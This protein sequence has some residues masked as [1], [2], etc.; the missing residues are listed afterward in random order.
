MK[1]KLR[2]RVLA[3]L[4]SLVL[5]VGLM[6]GMS[7]TAFAQEKYTLTYIGP[8][9]L[10]VYI[11]RNNEYH[12]IYTG[13]SC[14]IPTDSMVNP[15]ILTTFPS[16]LKYVFSAS[17]KYLLYLLSTFN[18]PYKHS[19]FIS[20]MRFSSCTQRLQS[21]TPESVSIT[22]EFPSMEESATISI[23]IPAPTRSR[24]SSL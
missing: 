23:S 17:R 3:A 13:Q 18:H 2:S 21:N 10:I 1:P 7:T 19:D 12:T 4:L 24:I 5:L 20:F 15:T 11:V 6:T 22:Q 14:S 16:R 8:D 9:H